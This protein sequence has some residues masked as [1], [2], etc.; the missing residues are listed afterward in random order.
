MP[1]SMSIVVGYSLYFIMNMQYMIAFG[2]LAGNIMMINNNTVDNYGNDILFII[3]QI[4]LLHFKHNN[5]YKEGR[6]YN[7]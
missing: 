2:V 4:I 5:Y 6:F 3:K 1:S 7:I